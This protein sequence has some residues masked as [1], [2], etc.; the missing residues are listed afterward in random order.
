MTNIKRVNLIGQKFGRLLV[1]G[2]GEYYVSPKGAKVKQWECKCDCGNTTFASTIQL[3]DGKKKSCGCLTKESATLKSKTHGMYGSRLYNIYSSMV[4]RCTNPNN[5]D[6]H[7]YGGRG[8][9]VCEEWL[10]FEN[11]KKWAIENGYADDLTIDR[12]DVNGNYEPS[13][14]RWTSSK[15]QNN[16][17]RNNRLLTFNGET[18]TMAEWADITGIRYAVLA[19]RIINHKWSV[20]RALTQ[21]VRR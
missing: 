19:C 4:Q 20:E 21:E 14:C 13:N 6:F 10:D 5:T 16:N 17:R 9:T 8:I 12:A 7:N 2:V 1:V 11:F 15:K 18:H 3:H